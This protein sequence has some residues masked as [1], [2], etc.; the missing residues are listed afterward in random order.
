MADGFASCA[1]HRSE[2]SIEIGKNKVTLY[3]PNGKVSKVHTMNF[4]P[5]SAYWSEGPNGGWCIVCENGGPDRGEYFDSVG[6]GTLP[7]VTYSQ[8]RKNE[9]E[10]RLRE[11]EAREERAR[12]SSWRDD[13]GSI[14]NSIL[15]CLAETIP[16]MRCLLDC[17]C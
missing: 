4:Q 17:F 10:R 3:D 7:F 6:V 16:G 15:N 14:G 11:L 9:E 8:Y 13:H 1:D 12:S 2:C 5:T